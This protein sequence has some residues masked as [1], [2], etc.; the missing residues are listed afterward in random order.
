MN[1]GQGSAIAGTEH[2]RSNNVPE[3]VA[4]DLR[5]W[6]VGT[7]AKTADIEP[8]SPWEN[9][10]CETFNSNLRDEFLN[11]EI[12]YS[13]KVDQGHGGAVALRRRPATLFAGLSTT[14]AGGLGGKVLA[15]VEK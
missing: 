15:G 10:Y 1:G 13:I 5:K 7:G 8:G 9:G 4:R 14:G 12:F 3:F 6:L 2:L 11:G